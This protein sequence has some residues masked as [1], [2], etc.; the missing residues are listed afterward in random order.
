MPNTYTEILVSK[1]R[2]NRATTWTP[3]THKLDAR[4]F[5]VIAR[6]LIELEAR[7]KVRILER[8]PLTKNPAKHC[9]LVRFKRIK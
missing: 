4:G 8:Q 3:I 9:D 2:L 7:G 5:D 1:L 6:R